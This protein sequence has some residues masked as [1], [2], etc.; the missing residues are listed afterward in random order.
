MPDTLVPRILIVDDEEAVL[1]T[2]RVILEGAGYEP[3]GAETCG[4]ALELLRNND[5][6]LLLCDL[7]LD[8]GNS[9]L[10]VISAAV[11]KRHDIPT[12]LMTGYADT[13]LP[14]DLADA[15]VTIML[16]PISVSY[17]LGRIESLL[18]RTTGDISGDQNAAD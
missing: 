14:P 1:T 17:L 18:G 10:D 7:S 12:I 16:K 13:E 11:R 5:F 2:Y 15:R 8:G 3:T 9:G 4:A 6:D